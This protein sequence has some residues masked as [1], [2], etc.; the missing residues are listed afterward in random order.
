MTILLTNGL[1]FA[2]AELSK[3]YRKYTASE[4]RIFTI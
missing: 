1:V 3:K 2:F 4:K